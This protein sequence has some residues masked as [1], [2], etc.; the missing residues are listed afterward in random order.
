MAAQMRD[1]HPVAGRRQQRGDI[2]KAVNIVGPAVQKDDNRT[3]G[4][5][6]LGIADIQDAGIDLLQ[7]T[8]GRV[9]PRLY[10]G[11]NHLAGLCVRGTDRDEFGGSKAYGCDA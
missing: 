6:G 7:W 3:I 2:D 8:E 4:G 11:W 5:A 9:R 1:D 10:R